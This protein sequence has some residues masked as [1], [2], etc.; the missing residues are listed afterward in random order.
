MLFNPPKNTLL[1]FLPKCHTAAPIFI[2]PILSF[3]HI[4]TW[5]LA[6]EKSEYVV[7]SLVAVNDIKYS[8]SNIDS[9]PKMSHDSPSWSLENC[10]FPYLY[11]HV[12]WPKSELNGWAIVLHCCLIISPFCLSSWA[13]FHLNLCFFNHWVVVS[14]FLGDFVVILL[15]IL[16]LLLLK[17]VVVI[18]SWV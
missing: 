1:F 16:L 6:W 11:M 5:V 13:S 3:S 10:L 7:F 14:D 9:S 8:N 12:S 4:Y 17:L 15:L 2:Q 18:V